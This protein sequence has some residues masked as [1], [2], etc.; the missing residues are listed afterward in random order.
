MSLKST[1]NS[2]CLSLSL[3]CA[4]SCGAVYRNRPCLRRAGGMGLTTITPNCVRRSSPGHVPVLHRQSLNQA[5]NSAVN[6]VTG[7]TNVLSH[8][9]ATLQSWQWVSRSGSN[10]STNLDGSRG[11][12]DSTRDPLAHFTLYSSGIPRDFPV[13]GKPAT[14]ID[15]VNLF[16]LLQ[17]SKVTVIII[18][19]IIIT[20]TSSLQTDQRKCQQ[21]RMRCSSEACDV[22]NT[23]LR[24]SRTSQPSSMLLQSTLMQL[25]GT[26]QTLGRCP[27]AC[28]LKCRR[29][30]KRRIL[31]QN[32]HEVENWQVLMTLSTTNSITANTSTCIYKWTCH[33]ERPGADKQCLL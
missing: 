10:G 23:V 16:W 1:S 33:R 15:T 18:I 11:S 22:S 14:A 27:A 4:L 24:P 28:V 25:R 8:A 30:N 7:F 13:H 32:A 29:L 19:I 20:I 21:R 9:R 12:R 17:L 31:P 2:V 3:H 6:E 26:S 5:E